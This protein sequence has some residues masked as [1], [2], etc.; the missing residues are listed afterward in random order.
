MSI[1]FQVLGTAGGDNAMFVQVDSGQSVERLLFDC[2]EGCLSSLSFGEILSL[3]QVFFSHL[4]MDHIAGFDS[5]FRATFNR[6]S[7]PNQLWG[8]PDTARILQHR[9]QGFL[10][11]LQE[12]MTGSWRVCEIHPE[13]IQSARF[14]LPEAFATRHE[15]APRL[16]Q[17]VIWEGTGVT[18]EAVTME[19][20]T[21]TLAYIIREKPRRNVDLTRLAALGLRPGSWMKTLKEA[22]GSATT[23]MIEGSMHSLED[24]RKKLIV[25]TPGDTIAYLTDFL[26]D[27]AAMERLIPALQGCRVIV[28]EGQYRHS[29]LDLAKKN[30]H[31]TTVL[32]ATLAQRAQV[33]ELVLFHLSDRYGREEWLEMLAEA[34]EI[35]PNTRFP[36]HWELGNG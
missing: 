5:F 14:E 26:L 35:F 25:E 33:D 23:V 13:E 36:A 8:P 16:R 15:D 28:C 32:S 24:L 6:T 9:F 31:M 11:N 3:D 12:E 21:P 34:R 10:W 4:H 1:T 7:K 22:S 2:G 18:V 20:R 27:E 30:F 19:H 17:R 29:D